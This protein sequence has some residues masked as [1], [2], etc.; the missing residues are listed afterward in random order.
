[1]VFA[2]IVAAG[3][4]SLS[5]RK[6]DTYEATTVVRIVPGASANALDATALQSLAS[7]YAS[8]ARSSEVTGAVNVPNASLSVSSDDSGILNMSATGPDPKTVAR[9]SRRYATV[10]SRKLESDADARRAAVVKR[11]ETQAAAARRELGDH[12]DGSPES[13]ALTSA[14]AS[15]QSAAANAQT[16]QSDEA[17][18]I[19]PATVPGSPISPRPKRDAILALIAAL[20]AGCAVA[21]FRAALSNRFATA[22]EVAQDLEL[23][24][25]ADIPSGRRHTT[26]TTD[27]VR[28]LRVNVANSWR[29]GPG[30]NGGG[31]GGSRTVLV[32]SLS[33]RAPAAP[34]AARLARAFAASGIRAAAVDANLR[35]P[36]LNRELGVSLE[37]G[38]V[39]TLLEGTPL[40]LQPAANSAV[41]T[42]AAGRLV[43]GATELL[44]RARLAAVLDQLRPGYSAIVVT[45][46]PVLAA[47]ES[48]VV[49]T[50]VDSVVVVVD[51]STSRR[52]ARRALDSLRQSG[53]HVVGF[54]YAQGSVRKD[55]NVDTARAPDLARTA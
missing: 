52:D 46:P 32:A 14:L 33:S 39:D 1:M 54:V 42:L 44:T 4:Y 53:A 27:A 18:T 29:G 25:L 41:M 17:E 38:L 36:R 10:F 24:L 7:S 35:S 37:P 6:G 15:L 8:L 55:R 51:A 21:Y 34:I 26:A 9:A 16:Q 19:S 3:A 40:E 28:V 12:S 48:I 2:I 47:A 22:E 5:S 23:P 49:A 11:I 30:E 13:Q 43:E 50:T 45:A 31:G 20:I